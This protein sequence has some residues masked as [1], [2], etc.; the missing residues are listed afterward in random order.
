MLIASVALVGV[1][2]SV[3][4]GGHERK[5]ERLYRKASEAVKE[6]RLEEAVA[7]F[8]EILLK[9]P[10]TEAAS[11]AAEDIEVYRGI[12][13]AVEKFPTR[14]ARDRMIL[15]ARALD[16]Y[17]RRH[18]SYPD[19]LSRLVPDYLRAEPTDSWGRPFI[20][21]TKRGGR[22]YRLACRG[23]DSE[24][25][26]TGQASDIVIENGAFVRHGDAP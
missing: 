25:G 4:C 24:P 18:R 15:T 22:G 2:L 20:Y 19:R 13:G 5:A 1:L 8:D 17:R 3:A 26:G 11:H 14:L 9:Y 12:A 10:E 23:S 6:Q 16:R 21:E 7:L